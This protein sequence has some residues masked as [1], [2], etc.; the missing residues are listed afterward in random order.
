MGEE[1]FYLEISRVALPPTFIWT[2]PSSHP[3]RLLTKIHH[4]ARAVKTASY[5]P[6][7]TWPTPILVTKSPRPIELSNLE[8]EWDRLV[9]IV[10]A[11]GR[12]VVGRKGTY[13]LPLLSG[14]DSSL[15]Y[16]V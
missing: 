1:G 5:L 11:I 14:L 6:L 9:P 4:E 12:G 8:R 3:G 2:T 7:M 16:P 13:L 15:R 10:C